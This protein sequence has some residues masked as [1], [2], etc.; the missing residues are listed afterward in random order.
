MHERRI[1]IFCIVGP[2]GKL[3]IRPVPE[4]CLD[5]AESLVFEVPDTVTHSFL[6][7]SGTSGSQQPWSKNAGLSVSPRIQV[8]AEIVISVALQAGAPDCTASIIVKIR[9]PGKCHF[10]AT[11]SSVV[12]RVRPSLER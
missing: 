1:R 2:L 10:K 6:V 3:D 9:K 4:I 8:P 7:L 5:E 12:G 11:S